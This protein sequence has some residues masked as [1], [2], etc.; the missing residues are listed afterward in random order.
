M[1]EEGI[2]QV[3]SLNLAATV[4]NILTTTG[5]SFFSTL[6]LKEDITDFYTWIKDGIT[7]IPQK[8]GLG[9]E[10][11]FDSLNKYTVRTL[12]VTQ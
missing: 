4:T 3:S 9:F 11:N 6:R 5:H 12:R 8:P 7:Y 2:T 1:L 10:V